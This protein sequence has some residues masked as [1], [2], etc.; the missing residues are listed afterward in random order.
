[1][2][3]FVTGD[4]I[5]EIG[6]RRALVIWLAGLSVYVLAIF[7]RSSLG[8]AGLL[9]S[10]R[11]DIG[12]TQLAFFTVLQLAVY[13]VMQIPVGVL[14][15]RFGSRAL[16]LVGLGLMTAG[17]LAFAFSTN[18]GLAVLARAVLGAGDAMIFVSVIR[19]VTVWFLVRQAPLFMQLTGL[20][21]QVGA[22][23]AA[24][25]LTLALHHL[26]WTKAFAGA[27]SLGMLLMVVVLALVKD[28]PYQRRDAIRTKVVVLARSLRQVWGHPATRH[29]MWLHFTSQFSATA[30][31]M[32]WGFPFL[33]RGEGMTP[34]GAGVLMMAMT[35]WVVLSG[36]GLSV[37]VARFPFY[38]SW[39]VVTIVA[40][41]ATAWTVVLL[42][43]EPA[44]LWLL[45]VL[46]FTVAT[47]G[48]ASMVGFDL[49]RTFAPVNVTGR[50]NGLINAGGFSASLLAMGLIGLVLD[51]RSPG[52]T[53]S[54]DLDDF[55]VAL[56]VQY[57]FWVLGVVQI[58]R[59]RRRSIAWLRRE[60]PGAVERL[61]SGEHVAH[62]GMGDVEGV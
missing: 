35:G 5:H 48:P 20:I 45:V 36:L 32:L 54:Y 6:R 59:Y 56:C 60:H 49:A 39:I 8:V 30:F 62:V 55:R 26:G 9:A 57:A 25:P 33:V 18:F 46:V 15:D 17:Q 14:L 12:A 21:G 3:S 7:H 19:L 28:S 29:G 51:W 52:G 11:F 40:A 61:R 1:M 34:T 27:S 43:S 37:L 2:L 23:V 4:Q 44:P 47:G 16:L 13:A 50:A 31:G 24:A 38:R 22:I 58:L 41:I 10:E 53:A 42:R